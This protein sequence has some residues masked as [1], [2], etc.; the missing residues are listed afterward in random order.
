VVKLVRREPESDALEALDYRRLIASELLV[1]EVLRAARR[2][3]G[4]EGVVA[5]RHVLDGIEMMRY[6]AEIRDR[7][8][9][10]DPPGLSTLDAI[11][12]A[13]A[14]AV[15]PG[16]EAFLCYDRRLRDAAAAVGLEVLSPGAAAG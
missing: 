8:A 2:G 1:V 6:T 13:S 7:A 16:V 15:E 9:A 14:L 3:L 5:A 4:T 10:L 12:L 11:H